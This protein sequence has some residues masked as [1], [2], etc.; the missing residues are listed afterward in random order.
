MDISSFI[1]III[2]IVLIYFVIKFV[3]SPIVKAILSVIIF[4]ILVY[5]LQRFL[6]F[7]I[8][9]VLAPFGISLNLGNWGINLDWLLNPINYYADQ[10]KIFIQHAWTNV[11][12]PQ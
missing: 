12:K 10:I 9:Q 1:T 11:P 7:D 4:L 5:L 8:D 2:A 3:V 6:G